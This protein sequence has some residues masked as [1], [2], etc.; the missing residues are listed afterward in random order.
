MSGNRVQNLWGMTK[1]VAASGREKVNI[2]RSH[3]YM[4]CKIVGLILTG[5]DR[6]VLRRF[7]VGN[8]CEVFEPIP[9]EFFDTPDVKTFDELP[10]AV[11]R[12]QVFGTVALGGTI[13]EVEVFG[14]CEGAALLIERIQEGTP[15]FKV[16]VRENNGEYIGI[17]H[18]EALAGFYPLWEIRANSPSELD[19][20]LGAAITAVGTQS[21]YGIRL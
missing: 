2:F 20:L 5:T 17:I 9:A 6:S 8:F 16:E 1:D 4:N 10:P 19:K 12:S 15:R 7:Q 11:K 3:I 21:Q 18:T 14:P 13:A